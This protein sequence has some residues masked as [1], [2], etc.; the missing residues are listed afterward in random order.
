M[1]EG[2][3]LGLCWPSISQASDEIR[4]WHVFSLSVP[5]VTPGPGDPTRTTLQGKSLWYFVK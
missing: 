3:V 4:G 1:H 2:L 5:V